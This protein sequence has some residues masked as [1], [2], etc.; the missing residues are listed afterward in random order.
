MQ[1]NVSKKFNPLFNLPKGVDL[2]II[3]GGR[4]SQKSFAVALSIVNGCVKYNYRALYTR[5]TSVSLRDSIF[6]EVTEKIE[7]LN[8]EDY[9]EESIN[10]IDS[11]FN[12]SKIVFKGLKAGS[13]T[14]TA[15]LKGFKDFSV[16]VLEEGEEL[17]EEALFDKL[18]LSIRGNKK[19]SVIPNI[20]III[21]N[22]TSKEHFI[23]KKY[24]LNR[25][26]QE[27]FNGVKDN[28]CYIHTTYFD[29]IEFV[30][31]EIIRY[32]DE[33]KANNLTKYNH[34]VLGGWLDKAEGVVIV[35]WAYGEFNPDDLQ[36]TFGQDFGFSVDPTTLIEVAIDKKKKKIYAKEHLYKPKLTT[37][38]IAY[39]NNEVAGYSLIIADSAEPRLIQELSTYHLGRSFRNNIVGAEKGPGSI[40]LG[41][42]LLQDYEIVVERNSINLAKELNNYV[43]A[44]KGSKLFVD[45]FNHLIDPLRYVVTYHLGR[46]FGIEIR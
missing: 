17:T 8:W 12:N 37:S 22:P 38:Q 13:G 26:V 24:Y 43:Y 19:G 10:R 18:L 39:I 36:T 25:G 27:G 23:Y 41:I 21:L 16:C 2:F 46:S 29:C 33:M 45:A 40:S 6:P 5:Y 15:N 30:P 7:M 4:Y 35:N 20:K 34:I 44:D 42:A 11:K 31:N 14:Q 9:F 32:F 1:I 3:T 28:V